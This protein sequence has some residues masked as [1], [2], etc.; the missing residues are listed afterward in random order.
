MAWNDISE[1]MAMTNRRKMRGAD[2]RQIGVWTEK[3]W[4]TVTNDRRSI[5]DMSN[6]WSSDEPWKMW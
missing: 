3:Q 1:T 4:Q 2:K 6:Q 5:I